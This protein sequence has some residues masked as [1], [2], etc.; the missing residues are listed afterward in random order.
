MLTEDWTQFNEQKVS[1]VPPVA[2]LFQ[3]AD[4]SRTTIFIGSSVNLRKELM[5]QLMPTDLCLRDAYFYK[6][7]I[8]PEL[9]QGVKSAFAAFREMNNGRLPRCNK[10]DYTLR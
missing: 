3:F 9:Y 10:L 4:K 1:N 2:G 5:T 7:S 8:S 6:V